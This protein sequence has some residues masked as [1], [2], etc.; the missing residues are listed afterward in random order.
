MAEAEVI[1]HIQRTQLQPLHPHCFRCG[2]A[3]SHSPS[4]Y[5]LATGR[6]LH[7]QGVGSRRLGEQG[8]QDKATARGG[9]E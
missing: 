9:G 3:D 2:F 4:P 5:H 8:S 1:G 7:W 6:E